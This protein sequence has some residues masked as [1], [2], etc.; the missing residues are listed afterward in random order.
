MRGHMAILRI[1]MTAVILL[2]AMEVTIVEDNIRQSV[3]ELDFALWYSTQKGETENNQLTLDPDGSVTVMITHSRPES[4]LRALGWFYAKLDFR[5]PLLTDIG[6]V[7]DE[8]ALFTNEPHQIPPVPGL[9]SKIFSIRKEGS[10]IDHH[11]DANVPLPPGLAEL[12]KAVQRLMIRLGAGARRT[13]AFGLHPE[14]NSLVWGD[15]LRVILDARND[16]VAPAIIR[17]PARFSTT[18][19]NVLKVNFWSRIPDSQEQEQYN[20]E[21]TLDLSNREWLTAQRRALDSSD[22]YLEIAPGATLRMW[23][24]LR[25]PKVDP[26]HYLAQLVY[27]AIPPSVQEE[28][29]MPELIVGEFHSDTTPIAITGPMGKQG[30]D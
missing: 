19:G 15:E 7:I 16:G 1:V 30:S 13:V 12:E 23:T 18:G 17:N 21:W 10:E 14:P 22:P 25:C 27:Y 3:N 11:T 29:D 8:N 5:D 9:R 2:I 26:K 20:Y 6:R 28:N 4:P 24:T